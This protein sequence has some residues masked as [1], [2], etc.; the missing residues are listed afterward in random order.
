M[1]GRN[2]PPFDALVDWYI[3]R[4]T[5]QLVGFKIWS[6]AADHTRSCKA[7]GAPDAITRIV[8]SQRLHP[9]PQNLAQLT[10]PN[11][12]RGAR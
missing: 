12:P 1:R 7:R 3:D 10:G 5:A 9:T 6:C 11:A 4:A 2:A 8:T